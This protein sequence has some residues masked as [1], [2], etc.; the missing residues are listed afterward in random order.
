MAK[1]SAY[2][3]EYKR[4]LIPNC[5]APAMLT[6]EIASSEGPLTIGD[7][8]QYTSG[9]LTGCPVDEAML[10]ILAG[11]VTSSGE[12]IFKTKETHGCTLSGD[13]TVTTGA[14]NTTTYHV[15]GLVIV[16]DM[17]LFQAT[18]NSTL[19]AAEVGLYCDGIASSGSTVDMVSGTV[20]SWSVG[21]QQF[22]LIEL[23]TTL[24][25]GSASTTTG[26]FRIIRTQLLRDVTQGTT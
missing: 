23:V 1:S 10:G 9:Y 16:D 8:V 2:G 14:S 18:A 22:Q 6:V 20:G 15:K 3:F 24:Q 26:L 4:H 5:E 25:D 21:T 17:A 19:S 13:D 12:N 11:V 7:A